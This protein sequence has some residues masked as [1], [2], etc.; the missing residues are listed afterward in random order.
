MESALPRLGGEPSSSLRSAL[1]SF[2]VDFR[3]AALAHAWRP[4]PLC[5]EARVVAFH[6]PGPRID[7]AAPAAGR[8]SR[9]DLVWHR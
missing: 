4:F 5:I 2:R 7:A 1:P 6:A 9:R 3:A 8:R